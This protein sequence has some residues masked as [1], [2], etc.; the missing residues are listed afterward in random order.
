MLGGIGV[1]GALLGAVALIAWIVILVWLAE[2]ILRYIGIRTSWGPLD[3]RN[4]LITFA[5]LT[6]VIHLANYLLDQIDNSMG[7]SDGGVPLTFPGAF[8]IGSVAMAVGV[9]AVRW[10][11][12][13]GGRK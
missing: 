5:L 12:K 4:V 7:G 6:G 13:Q 3:P 2:R 8:L 11:W 10:R 9:A 1:G